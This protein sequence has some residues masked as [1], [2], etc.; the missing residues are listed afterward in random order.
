MKVTRASFENHV[1]QK[2]GIFILKMISFFKTKPSSTTLWYVVKTPG[3]GR[4]Q[5]KKLQEKH[6]TRTHKT[7]E[8]MIYVWDNMTIMISETVE[9]FRE[10]WDE[11]IEDMK[12]ALPEPL[13]KTKA[14]KRLKYLQAFSRG[15]RFMEEHKEFKKAKTKIEDMEAW[16]TELENQQ[17]AELL[18]RHGMSTKVLHLKG[19]PH[20]IWKSDHMVS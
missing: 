10:R 15:K 1:T 2:S 5:L 17:S 4:K 13:I 6:N 19:V 7:I 14:E 3:A 8:T 16:F 12:D 18:T 11:L 20:M 9:D